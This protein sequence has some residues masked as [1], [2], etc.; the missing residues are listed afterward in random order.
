MC[1]GTETVTRLIQAHWQNRANPSQTEFIA[2][3]GP[4]NSP[5]DVDAAMA[6]AGEV[7]E[8]RRAECPDG[9]VPMVCNQDAPEFVM[10]ANPS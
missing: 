4:I 8:R 2:Q 7:F 9:W 6:W 3:Y 10:A 1:P 5:E